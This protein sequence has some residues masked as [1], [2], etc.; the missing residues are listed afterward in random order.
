VGFRPSRTA[1]E[2]DVT[3]EVDEAVK[4]QIVGAQMLYAFGAA[5]CVISTY[6]ALGFILLVQLNY[7][8]APRLRFLQRL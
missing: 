7:A 2:P 1:V 6:W 5:L 8:L 3:E 4:R